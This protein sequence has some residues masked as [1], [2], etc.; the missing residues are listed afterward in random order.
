MSRVTERVEKFFADKIGQDLPGEDLLELRVV[1]PGDEMKADRP[2]E[3]VLLLEAA[4]VLSQEA[5]EMMKHHPV[6]H[7][8]LRM[9]R[10]ILSRPGGRN[11]PRIGPRSAG[12][13]DLPWKYDFYPSPDAEIKSKNVNRS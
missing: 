2:E 13:P 11:A 3:A 10:T 9:P 4:L 6:E 7:G 8:A 5:I 1:D 12:K